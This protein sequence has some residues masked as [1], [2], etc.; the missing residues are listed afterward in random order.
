[1]GMSVGCKRT[2][3]RHALEEWVPLGVREARR[4]QDGGDNHWPYV[5]MNF[6]S[7]IILI[8]ALAIGCCR[9]GAQSCQ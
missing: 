6:V 5:R 4:A 8:A 3:E 2:R 9:V 7:I 1:M